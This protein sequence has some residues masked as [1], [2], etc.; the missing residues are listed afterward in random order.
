MNLPTIND[1]W[2]I[3]SQFQM[4][5]APSMQGMHG[6]VKIPNINNPLLEQNIIHMWLLELQFQF[7]KLPNS[8]QVE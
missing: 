8:E 6:G 1:E 5:Q 7:K 2:S 3:N 4:L